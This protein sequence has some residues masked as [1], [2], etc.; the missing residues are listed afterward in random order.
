MSAR[1]RAIATIVGF[2]VLLLLGATMRFYVAGQSLERDWARLIEAAR[3]SG[4]QVS[5]KPGARS[6]WP[7]AP[8]LSID[9]AA[10][11]LTRTVGLSLSAPT[12]QFSRPPAAG[13]RLALRPAAPLTVGTRAATFRLWGDQASASFDGEGATFVAVGL[14]AGAGGPDDVMIARSAV[15]RARTTAAATS[16]SFAINGLTLPHGHVAR[17]ER[18]LDRLRLEAT[19]TRTPGQR[20]VMFALDADWDGLHARIAGTLGAGTAGTLSGRMTASIGPGWRAAVARAEA[21]RIVTAP[22]AR[23][24]TGLLALI[25]TG[26]AIHDMPLAVQDGNVTLGGLTLLRLPALPPLAAGPS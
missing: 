9:E 7:F 23:A 17:D 24:A 2:V 22:E 12:L 21:A 25:A 16:V 5:G 14:H 13:E 15:G 3:S 18:T 10:L 26:D 4:W 19:L 20:T 11:D 6:G 1:P 8:S